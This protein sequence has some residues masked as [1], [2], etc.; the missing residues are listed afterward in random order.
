LISVGTPTTTPAF[1]VAGTSGGIPY[2]ASSSTWA[3]TAAMTAH[4]VMVG[5]G[6]ATAPTSTAAGTAGRPL[7]SNR[8]RADPTFQQ[9]TG[10]LASAFITTSEGTNSTSFVDLSTPDT[11]TFSCDATCNFIVQYTANAAIAAAVTLTCYSSVF[12]DTVQ[13]DDGNQGNA[14]LGGTTGFAYATQTVASWKASSQ[15]SGSHT[16]NIKHKAQAGNTCN[17]NDRFLVVT[18]A[19]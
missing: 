19:P 4:G 6:A 3:T 17:W 11:V 1:T 9:S 15:A 18:L 14:L 12:I 8:S 10:V 5:G 2:F 13:V 16:V 7:V